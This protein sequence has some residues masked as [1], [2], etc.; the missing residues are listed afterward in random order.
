MNWNAHRSMFEMGKYSSFSTV[1]DGLSNTIMQ[2]ESAGRANW[3][4]YRTKNPTTP[5][6]DYYGTAPWGTK[7]EP[8]AGNVAGGW[9]FPTVVSLNPQ[10]NSVNVTWFVGSSVMN[11]SNWYGNAY[12]FHP[13]G[14]TAGMGDGSVRFLK[15]QT[16]VEVLSSLT[17]R[18]GGEVISA[19]GF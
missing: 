4:V 17:S 3:Y 12:S 5:P 8:W 6:F 15:Q 18:D 11:V 7:V 13:E 9:I 1:T 16:A 14:I 19:D 10:G 2:Y